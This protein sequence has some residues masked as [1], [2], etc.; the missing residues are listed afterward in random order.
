MKNKIFSKK[1]VVFLLMTLFLTFTS[2]VPKVLQNGTVIK[3]ENFY[4]QDFE[5]E[6]VELLQ[7]PNQMILER[8]LR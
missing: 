5:S 2:A 1:T 8:F 7:N 4:A 6:E 3:L